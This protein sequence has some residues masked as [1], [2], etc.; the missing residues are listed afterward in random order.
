MITY[1]ERGKAWKLDTPHTSYVCALAD[2]RYLA[3]VWY[4]QKV[5][6]TD[7]SYLLRLQEGPRVPSENPAEKQGFLDV[8]PMEYPCGGTGDFRESAVSV[9]NEYGQE[10]LELVFRSYCIVDGK[11]PI[12]GLPATFAGPSPCPP[13]GG[14]HQ[15]QPGDGNPSPSA[16]CR[17]QAAVRQPDPSGASCQTLVITLSDPLLHLSVDLYYTAFDDADVITR[18]ARITNEGRQPLFLT[19]ALSAVLDAEGAGGEEA[20]T[21]TGTWAREHVMQRTPV[22]GSA[23]VSQSLRGEPGHDGQPFIA[24]LSE[25]TDYR[26]GDV[27]GMHLVYSG[28]YLGTVRENAFSSIRMALGINPAHFRW[29]L[30]G[31]ESFYTPEAVLVFSKD[32]LGGMSRTLHDFYRA[33]LIRRRW[34]FEE[35]PVLVNNWEAT[36]FDFDEEK[37]LAIADEASRAGL[38]L[39]VVDD[40]WFGQGRCEPSGSLGD[41]SASEQK[42]PGGIPRLSGELA[43]RNMKLGLWFEP[44]MISENSDLYRAHPDW[45]LQLYGRTPARCRDQFVLDFSNPDVVGYVIR[46]IESILS[47]AP[48]AYLKWD[49]NRPLCDAGS[50]YL[51]ADRQGEVWHR[52]VLGLYRIQETILNDFPDLLLENCSSGGARFDP[53]M[54]YYSPQIWTSDDMDVVERAKI[55]E[56][57]ELLYPIS[58]MGSHVCKER[59]DITGRRVPL[60]TRVFS[61]MAGT[62]GYELDI[63]RMKEEEKKMIARQASFYRDAV[64]PLVLKGDYF[65]LASLSENHRYDAIELVSKDRSEAIV[66]FLQALAQPNAKSTRL[67]LQGLC[68]DA[69]YRLEKVNLGTD[70]EAAEH[71]SHFTDGPVLGGLDGAVLRGDTLMG[72]GMLIEHVREDFWSTMIRIR[73][74]AA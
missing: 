10:G 54:L 16:S 42:L 72:A 21:Y 70:R 60:A 22:S 15:A 9:E 12:P 58:A 4:G 65:R 28:D 18:S 74:A 63:T 7:L 36:Y 71:E 49:M 23:V 67:V 32:G 11:P 46:S 39:L 61:A 59:N 40:G 45:V 51:P 41:W 14:R 2:G 29:K 35:R 43:K 66:F 64:R 13:S 8:C 24:L 53:G 57:T 25:G 37:L 5:S 33:H 34:A 3:H 17:K 69:A 27:T 30:E 55:N 44:E 56:G 68:P 38:D 1:S 73:L 6:D 19:R 52:H 62:F 50:A 26:K 47:S 20:L 48:V 31:G